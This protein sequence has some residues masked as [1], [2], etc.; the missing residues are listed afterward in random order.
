MPLGASPDDGCAV[1][2]F[3]ATL[4]PGTLAFVP[5]PRSTTSSMASLRNVTVDAFH[6]TFRTVCT[7]TRWMICR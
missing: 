5:V 7:P 6:L 4:I 2:V 3:P 1:P